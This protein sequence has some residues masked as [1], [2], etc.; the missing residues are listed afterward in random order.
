MELTDKT[1]LVT[2][3]TGLIG[4]NLVDALMDSDNVKVI[5]MGRNRK[6][7]ENTFRQYMDKPSFSIIEHDVAAPFPDKLGPVDLIFHAAGPIERDI[8][9]NHPMQVVLPNVMGSM[10]C[11]DFAK[12][13]SD[14][15]HV[16]P[17]IIV[18]S[19]V[20][21]YH[22]HTD[23]D[24]SVTEDMTSYAESL[25]S[26]MIAY[27]ESKRMSE[28]VAKSYFKQYDMD[29]V[30]ARF[31]TVYGFTKNVPDSAFYEFIRKA[32]RGE[33]IVVNKSGLPRRDNIYV[34]DAVSGL[35]QIA[36]SGVSGEA[37]NISSNGDGDNFA[38]VDEIAQTIMDA[39]TGIQGVLDKKI[40]V[41]DGTPVVNRLP[42]LML[43]NAKLK[44]LG[45]SVHTDLRTGI[46]ETIQRMKEVMD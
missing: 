46:T 7:M 2:G 14:K 17:R 20:T 27:S 25:S 40:Q 8:V 38:S 42:G 23:C 18:F 24:V 41:G 44:A 26:P 43:N 9:M 10:Y 31:S 13:Q 19:S 3:A 35:L 29:I 22:N 6:K 34:A 36:K 5:V 21:V 37:Y 4:S 15:Y 32:W 16:K 28:V 11:L 45:W 33:N 39:T 12:L 1:I 30:I